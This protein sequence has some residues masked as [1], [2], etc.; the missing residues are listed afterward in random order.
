M[1][2]TDANALLKNQIIRYW[3][4]NSFAVFLHTRCDMKFKNFIEMTASLKCQ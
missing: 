2:N 1:Q 4:Y 3:L